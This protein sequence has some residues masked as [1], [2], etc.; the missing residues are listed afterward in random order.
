M[1]TILE[2]PALVPVPTVTLALNAQ[3]PTPFQDVTTKTVPKTSQFSQTA[4]S[5]TSPAVVAAAVQPP[6]PGLKLP[7]PVN[8]DKLESWLQGYPPE[9]IAFLVNGFKF[10][11]SIGFQG[12]RIG[13]NC[14]LSKSAKSLPAIVSAKL[15]K[16]IAAGRISGPFKEKPFPNLH[17]S[18]LGLVPKKNGDFRLIHNLSYVEDN[19]RSP[20]VNQGIPRDLAHVQYAGVDDAI[21]AL[22]HIGR[23]SYMAKIDILQ[24]FRQL[25]VKPSDYSLLGF[26]WDGKYYFDRCLPMG[27]SSSCR[28]FEMLSTALEWIMRNKLAV[29]ACIHC[30]DD[31]WTAHQSQDGCQQFLTK[32]L[33]LCAD[34]GIPVAHEKTVGPAQTLVFLGIELDSVHMELRLPNDKIVKCIELLQTSSKRRKMK[35]REIQSLVGS[36][37]FACIAVPPGRAFLRRLIHLTKGVSKPHF[38]VTLNAEA[39][40]DMACWLQ[41]LTHFNGKNMF[42]EENWLSSSKIQLFTDSA[43]SY[44]FAGILGSRYFH[45]IFPKIWAD[46]NITFLEL[47]PIVIALYVWGRLLSN[48][49]LLIRTDNEALVAIINKQSSPDMIIMKGIRKLVLACLKFN[50]RVRA[51]HVAGS[52]NSR[53]DALSRGLIDKYKFLSPQS[54]D[55]PTAIPD[56]LMPPNFMQL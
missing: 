36:L 26:M 29:P 3:Q 8:A 33:T 43:A 18:P 16:E 50:I 42:L 56:D 17:L 44:G 11:F 38:Y 52:A 23:N 4:A 5:L 27:A 31:F 49:S 25:P 45:G 28:T 53:A 48:H 21:R 39:R 20:S 15:Q 10:G 54:R 9:K 55:V 2:K 51:C 24:A 22:K 7:T 1:H 12:E 40:A 14:P 13:Q 30:L 37:S 47:V 46:L 32:F 6:H 35:L 41:F 19:D 34:L